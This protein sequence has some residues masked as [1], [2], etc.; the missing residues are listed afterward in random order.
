[1]SGVYSGPSQHGNLENTT[2]HVSA[3][4]LEHLADAAFVAEVEQAHQD[5]QLATLGLHALMVEN[6]RRGYPLPPDLYAAIKAARGDEEVAS[7]P[8]K[9]IPTDVSCVFTDERV[10]F[11]QLRTRVLPTRVLRPRQRGARRR[12]ATSSRV[13]GS[14]RVSRS[15]SRSGDSGDDGSGEPEPRSR[16]RKKTAARSRR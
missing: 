6:A 2:H 7:M 10:P 1:M 13:R 12:R 4:E 5:G 14:R 15:S 9:E 3:A 11:G 16:G 8:V